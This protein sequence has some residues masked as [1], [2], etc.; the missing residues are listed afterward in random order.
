MNLRKQQGDLVNIWPAFADVAMFMVLILTFFFFFQFL[1]IA[2]R[3]ADRLLVVNNQQKMRNIFEEN[4]KEEINKTITIE[5]NG[6]IQRFK[7]SDRMLF[8]TGK[9]EIKEQGKDLLGEVRD[10]L[11]QNTHLYQ[12]IQIEGYT[13]DVPI[14]NKNFNSNWQLSSARAT[15]IVEFFAPKE[16]ES[17]ETYQDKINPG[18]LSATGFSQYQPATSSTTE[19]GKAMNRRIEIVLVY[20]EKSK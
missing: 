20:S 8:D 15:E 17:A 9:A 1:I 16:K 2:D 5:E 11:K 13:D 19:T 7:F 12:R 18:S 14:N 10:I 4:F 6:N 3:L